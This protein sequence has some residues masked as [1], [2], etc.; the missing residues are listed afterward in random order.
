MELYRC[1]HW[2]RGASRSLASGRLTARGLPVKP[3][4]PLCQAIIDAGLH[5]IDYTMQATT[6]IIANHDE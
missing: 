3:N 2:V 4:D 6:S 1:A 5:D